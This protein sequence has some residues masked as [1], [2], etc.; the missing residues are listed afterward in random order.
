MTKGK[1]R[2]GSKNPGGR[3]KQWDME[4][5][6][7]LADD[8]LSWAATGGSVMFL[9]SF[10]R[11]HGI[12][13]QRLTEFAKENAK[14]ADCL[15]IAQTTCEANIAEGTADGAIPPAFGIFGLKQHAWSDKHEVAH[16]G[17]VTIQ[18][19]PIDEAL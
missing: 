3:P 19:S 5:I 13:R 10:C 9:A 8:I 14:F 7:S 6:E 1:P 18:S 4:A 12:H 11:D 17:S 16:S 2:D 15:K